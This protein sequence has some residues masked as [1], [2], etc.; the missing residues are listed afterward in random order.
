MPTRRFAI[1]FPELDEIHSHATC[2]LI[3][4]FCHAVHVHAGES[5][6]VRCECVERMWCV[7]SLRRVFCMRDLGAISDL[8]LREREKR[9]ARRGFLLAVH[10][11]TSQ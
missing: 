3:S 10:S 4:D 9:T 5:M 8:A 1:H 2:L 11:A 7:R 6:C